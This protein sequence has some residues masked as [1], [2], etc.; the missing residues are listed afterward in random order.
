[1]KRV[2]LLLRE[3]GE[4]YPDE[5]FF[6]PTGCYKEL[7]R[8][9]GWGRNRANFAVEKNSFLLDQKIVYLIIYNG[10]NDYMTGLREFNKDT[11]IINITN[12]YCDWD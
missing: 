10:T 2:T 9:S 11:N 4:Y 3:N 6:V 8:T 1:M 5:F 7:V 12:H